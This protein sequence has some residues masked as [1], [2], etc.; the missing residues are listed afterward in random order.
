MRLRQ[1]ALVARELEPVLADLCEVLGA[2]E[3]FRDPGVAE[4]G[5]HNA[6]LAI[7]TSFLEVVSP[8]REGTTA[9]RLLERRGGDGGYM[10]IVQTDDLAADRKRIDELGIRVVWQVKLSD[11]ATMHLH[12]RDVGAAILSFDQMTPPESWRWAGPDWK[13]HVRADGARA[14]VGAELQSPD[15]AAL[16]ARWGQ[17]FAR[18]PVGRGDGSL[19]IPLDAG[20]LRFVR[21]GDGRGEGVGGIDIAVPDPAA[22]LAR[23]KARGLRVSGDTAEICGTR[24]RLVADR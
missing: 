2:E 9:G 22:A 13:K 11:A 17:V 23:A 1:I 19:E 18:K 7:G 21:A 6:L 8:V 4:F 5:L 14:I 3:C 15:P 12:P 24:I 20:T 16:A 10:V